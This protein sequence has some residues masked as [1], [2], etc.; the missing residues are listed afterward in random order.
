VTIPD[1]DNSDGEER[2]LLVG[3]TSRGRLIVVSHVERGDHT[4]I[5]SARIATRPE[6]REYEDS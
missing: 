4:R 1:P 3:V 2:R 5:I 6:R